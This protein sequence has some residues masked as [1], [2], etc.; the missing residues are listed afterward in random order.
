MGGAVLFGPGAD[1]GL[2]PKLSLHI[3][4]LNWD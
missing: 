4:Y 3:G 1:G 2:K